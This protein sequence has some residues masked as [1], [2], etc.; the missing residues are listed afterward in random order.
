MLA[1]Y[2]SSPLTQERHN[3]LRD[4]QIV[5]TYR[6]CYNVHDGI[7]RAD[8]MEVYL[9]FRDA[10]SLCLCFCQNLENFHR[11]LPCSVADGSSGNDIQYFRKPSVLM[12]VMM[13]MGMDVLLPV[14]MGMCMCVSVCNGM[15]AGL[16]FLRRMLT[17]MFMPV[18][19][20]HIVVMVFMPFVQ[21]YIEVAGVQPRFFHPADFYLKALHRK[22]F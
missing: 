10:V 2:G 20:F 18:Q 11:R 5:Q 1:S 22:A 15:I 12:S 4:I 7:H 14:R 6:R 16:F 9:I 19:I 3:H 13:F 21:L 8:L 17:V